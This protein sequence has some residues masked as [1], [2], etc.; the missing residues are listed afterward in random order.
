MINVRHILQ[1]LCSILWKSD[2]EPISVADIQNGKPHGNSSI[3]CTYGH[4]AHDLDTCYRFSA[5]IFG[6][7][8][9]RPHHMDLWMHLDFI[10]MKHVLVDLPGVMKVCT[11]Y[12]HWPY[13]KSFCSVATFHVKLLSNR[14][15]PLHKMLDIIHATCTVSWVLSTCLW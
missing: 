14:V 15:H 11:L 13:T 12:L 7:Q 2:S 6:S 10:T 8:Q 1:L 4:K 5:W 9:K 3:H